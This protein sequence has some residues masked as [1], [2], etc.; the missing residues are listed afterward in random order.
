MRNPLKDTL[1]LFRYLRFL[2]RVLWH[3]HRFSMRG[4]PKSAL[5]LFGRLCSAVEYAGRMS[6]DKPADL[7]RLRAALW[8]A[9]VTF[10]STNVLD[11]SF[12][13]SKES[14]YAS[15]SYCKL[16]GAE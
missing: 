4:D 14:T 2:L 15:D 9:L 11:E 13:F 16:E 7:L 12:H 8:E 1:F 3:T 6:G 5:W 10:Y